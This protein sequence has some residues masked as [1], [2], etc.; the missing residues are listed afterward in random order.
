MTAEQ[1]IAKAREVVTGRRSCPRPEPGEVQTDIVV[2]G[3]G[4]TARNRMSDADRVAAGVYDRD[5]PNRVRAPDPHDAP[6]FAVP[7]GL[8][9]VTTLPKTWRSMGGDIQKRPVEPNP[10]YEQLRRA[11]AARAEGADTPPP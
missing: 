11:E 7:G 5:G 3:R 9:N 8:M 1:A 4:E 10:A 6:D 2:C